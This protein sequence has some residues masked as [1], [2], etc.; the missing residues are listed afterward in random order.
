MRDTG[1]VAVADTLKEEAADVVAALKH[2]GIDVWMLTGD[3]ERT[4]N[5]IAQQVGITNVMSGV[6]PEDKVNKVAGLQ[7]A[8]HVV[9][10]VG[11]GINDS[12]AIAQVGVCV[13]VY[14]CCALPSLR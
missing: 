1:I 12:P 3:N 10:M 5:A 4:A 6:K 11:D 8:G 9:A 7:K 13:C 14:V 2:K